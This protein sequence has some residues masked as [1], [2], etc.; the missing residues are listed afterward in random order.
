MGNYIVL[1]VPVTAPRSVTCG[2]HRV[3]DVLAGCRGRDPDGDVGIG[4]D[5]DHESPAATVMP[6]RLSGA[7]TV[8]RPGLGSSSTVSRADAAA[9]SPAR[10]GDQATESQLPAE[11]RAPGTRVQTA[12]REGLGAI[13]AIDR[14]VLL[15]RGRPSLRPPRC[16]HG[17]GR[18]SSPPG[19]CSR[20]RWWTGAG[21]HERILASCAWSRGPRRPSGWLPT[22]TPSC[23]T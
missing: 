19:S 13:Y 4:E 9:G 6:L 16:G 2:R 21:F 23:P 20:V 15:M 10:V 5:D 8:R 3:V 22:A 11:N 12:I 18:T 1:V 17:C 14:V 7:A